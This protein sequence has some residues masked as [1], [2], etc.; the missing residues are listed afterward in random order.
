M[1]LQVLFHFAKAGL[2][3]RS[4]VFK[5]QTSCIMRIDIGFSRYVG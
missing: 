2:I 5:K 3:T 4:I 1:L